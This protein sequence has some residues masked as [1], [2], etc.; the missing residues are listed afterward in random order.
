[1]AAPAKP[2]CGHGA[3]ANISLCLIKLEVSMFGE[4]SMLPRRGAAD[5]GCA[6]EPGEEIGTVHR[7]AALVMSL[8]I[9]GGIVVAMPVALLHLG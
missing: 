8:A 7:V 6:S 9:A 5:R 4:S 2:V 1:M 3:A